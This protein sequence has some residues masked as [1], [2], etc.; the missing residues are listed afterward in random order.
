LDENTNQFGEVLGGDCQTLNE[1]GK[2]VSLA[3]KVKTEEMFVGR[4]DVNVEET[5]PQVP[6]CEPISSL[7][8]MEHHCQHFH[9]EVKLGEIL[10][11]DLLDIEP[12]V[13]RARRFTRPV[14]FSTFEPDF[15]VGSNVK[16]QKNLRSN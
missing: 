8:E 4:M 10:Y 2:L 11:V 6:T 13:C 15:F 7:D 14:S 3:F 16:C 1:T 5:L 12:R 9:L